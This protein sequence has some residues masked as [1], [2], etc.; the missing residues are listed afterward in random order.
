MRARL[1]AA[2]AASL[3]LAT[4]GTAAVATQTTA[5][6]PSSGAASPRSAS[7]DEGIR[8]LLAR[9]E[10]I[11]QQGDTGG[12][13][14]LLAD[15]VDRTGVARF[16]DSELL[17]GMTRAVIQERDRAPLAGT[18][19]GA[20]YTVAID[21]F[22]EFGD[23]ARVSNWTIDIRA[24]GDGEGEWRVV[25]AERLSSVEDLYR[26]SLNPKRQFSVKNLTLVDDD[27]RLTLRE[28]SLFV[29]E[30]DQVA[31][32]IVFLGAGEMTFSPAPETERSQVRIFSGAETLR[33]RF[34]A[35]Y[36]RFSPGDFDRLFS[37]DQLIAGAVDRNELRR[38]DRIFRED[39]PKSYTLDLGDLS[40]DSWSYVPNPRDLIAEVHTRR[41]DTLTYSRSSSA[42]EDVSLFD[43]NRRKTIALYNARPELTT[44]PGDSDAELEVSHYDIDVTVTPER[45][46]IEGRARLTIRARSPLSSVTLRLAESLAVQS[47]YS[48]RY[49][50][51]FN[52]R[53]R[54]NGTLIVSLPVTLSRGSEAV[55][56]V[57]YAGRLEPDNLDADL[58]AVGQLGPSAVPD[59]A[60]FDQPEPSFLYSGQSN[61][62]PRPSS[63]HHATAA[64]RITVPAT[65]G[66]VAT[67]E[68]DA[69]SPLS[70]A[71]SDSA[72]ARK[73]YVFNAIQPVRYL[74]FVLSRFATGRSESVAFAARVDDSFDR[75][76]PQA[77]KVTAEVNPGHTNRGREAVERATDIARFY[78][79][80]LHDS[81]YPSF[82]IALTENERAGGHSPGYFAVLNVPTPPLATF[83][84]RVDPASFDGYP[85]FF[86]AHEL[87]HQWWGQAVGWRSYREQ[88]LSEGFAQYFSALYARH[89]RGD[90]VFRT[91]M[92]QMRR[93]AVN[94]T[95]AGPISLGNRL[96]HIQGD[97]KILR[98]VVYNKGAL[99]LHMLR[100]LVGDEAFFRGLR[101]FYSD[102]RFRSVG[103]AEFRT[104]MEAEA[105]RPLARFFD[106]WIY[107]TALPNLGLT[108]RVEGSEVILR[109]EQRG[110]VFEVPVVISLQYSDRPPH[111]VVVP[112]TAS[113]VEVRVPL[114][115][116]LRGVDLSRDDVSLA[117]IARN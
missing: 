36:V 56:T 14:L 64:L 42:M 34:D 76:A 39:S 74:A 43:R 63:S 100:G 81:P 28:G 103:T 79:S 84:S 38:A 78:E 18:L 21:L 15:S 89:Q 92:R 101:R 90:D 102:S 29:S 72:T 24:S 109:V 41:F 94:Q 93:W 114:A 98:A 9:L 110:E 66:C 51:L 19:P 5:D 87:A 11:V 30:I 6:N 61:W 12:F 96:G 105:D 20:G 53:V 107:G 115:G 32:A 59:S 27:L 62:Y 108:H 52:M 65:L 57:R 99:V 113:L 46:W 50:R 73:Q 48:D 86:L 10:R 35:V 60:G 25:D 97:T 8:R 16:V 33:T 67:G 26:L 106:R 71:A 4:W 1:A 23:R 37:S 75:P 88:W 54:G 117:E 77:L 13:A 7:T 44:P 85:E 95:D 104:A 82:T 22:Q 80:L 112:V 49:G 70:L 45:R 58:V 68:R 111:D 47:V 3:A 116:T 17:P 2:V 91:V 31:T 69:A 40:R 55:L 83:P